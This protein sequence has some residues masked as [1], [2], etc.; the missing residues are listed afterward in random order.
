LQCNVAVPR[1]TAIS[2]SAVPASRAVRGTFTSPCFKSRSTPGPP[3]AA[4]ESPKSVNGD[5]CPAITHYRPRPLKTR[6]DHKQGTH[7]AVLSKITRPDS[8]PLPLGCE[9]QRSIP[10][11]LRGHK[12]PK[13]EQQQ[14][15]LRLSRNYKGSVAVVVFKLIA[16]RDRLPPMR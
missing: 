3:S 4:P 14:I 2:I 12:K 16:L 1:Q 10:R 8:N 9:P 5:R 15:K 6:M 13:P 11:E 7:A